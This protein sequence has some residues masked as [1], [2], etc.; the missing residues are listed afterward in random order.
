MV[1]EG[2]VRRWIPLGRA[3]KQANDRKAPEEEVRVREVCIENFK[4]KNHI[5]GLQG[6]R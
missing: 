1:T 4:T 3:K 5:E 2:R 6:M